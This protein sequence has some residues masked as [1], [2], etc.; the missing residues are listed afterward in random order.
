MGDRAWAAWYN[1]G[2][3][4]IDR[5]A[6][7]R[8][9]ERTQERVA[10]EDKARQRNGFECEIR[11]RAGLQA[12][13]IDNGKLAETWVTLQPLGSAWSDAEAQVSWTSPLLNMW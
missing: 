13:R 11:T 5:C 3:A 12:Y 1:L 2:R 9:D 6:I 10:G 8:I 4:L 7:D